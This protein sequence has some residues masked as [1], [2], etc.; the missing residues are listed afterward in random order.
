MTAPL[1]GEIPAQEM[2]QPEDV[3]SAVTWLLSLS[4]ACVVPEIPFLRP[5]NAA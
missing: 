4:P 1:Q 5:G 3:A 2:I